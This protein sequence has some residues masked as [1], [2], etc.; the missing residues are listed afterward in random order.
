MISQNIFQILIH[1]LLSHL[2]KEELL[3][4][5]VLNNISPSDIFQA[6]L[7]RGKIYLLKIVRLLL[8]CW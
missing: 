3:V 1:F 6:L 2:T 8:E 7:S 4:A 5:Y